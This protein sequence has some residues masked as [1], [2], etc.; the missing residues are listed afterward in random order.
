ML[1]KNIYIVIFLALCA[2]I[3]LGI[4]RFISAANMIPRSIL[5]NPH[6][7]VS[8][9]TEQGPI[10]VSDEED[11]SQKPLEPE[12]FIDTTPTEPVRSIQAQKPEQLQ[13][14]KPAEVKKNTSSK[15]PTGNILPGYSSLSPVSPD[16]GLDYYRPD[17][18]MVI[19]RDKI[20]TP[21][22]ICIRSGT[23]D[24]LL[25]MYATMA[26][27]NL[28]PM[29]V[30]GF[31]SS[32][33]QKN[34]QNNNVSQVLP[35]GT[36]IRS[37]A[38]PHHSEHQLGT[39]IDFAA[40]PAYN[41]KD[42]ENSPEY[43]WMIEH[44]A[45]YGFVQSYHYGDEHLTGYRGEPWHWRYIGSDHAQSVTSTGKILLEYLQELLENSEIKKP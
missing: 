35:N 34:I 6:D 9:Y 31:R 29:I 32:T 4:S 45:D 20:P 27:Q 21:H 42:F 28:K 3:L 43:A 1:R 37:V 30:S 25:L 13:P 23:L 36:I 40:A 12:V 8:S 5:I 38:L 26:E 11:L 24:A 7:Y 22:T 39:T 14:K 10:P 2:L 41:I 44:A 19:P 33:Y 17:D 15:C 16:F 18:L